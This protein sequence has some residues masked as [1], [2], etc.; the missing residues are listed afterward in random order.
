MIIS[1]KASKQKQY[2]GCY[3][4]LPLLCAVLHT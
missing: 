2:C 1:S 3:T 4:I